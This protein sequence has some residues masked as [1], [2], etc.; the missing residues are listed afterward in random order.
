M[1][2]CRVSVCKTGVVRVICTT[3]KYTHVHTCVHMYTLSK[4]LRQ[5]SY[6]TAVR[7]PDSAAAV[8]QLITTHK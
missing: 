3:L 2:M 4:D 7:L 8:I 5:N 6:C 1:C